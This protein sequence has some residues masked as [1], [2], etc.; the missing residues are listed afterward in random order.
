MLQIRGEGEIPWGNS[1]LPQVFISENQN[2]LSVKQ[3]FYYGAEN[4]VFVEQSLIFFALFG[5]G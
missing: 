5:L 2:K 1:L 3:G 4:V